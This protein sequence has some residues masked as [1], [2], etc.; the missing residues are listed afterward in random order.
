MSRRVEEE[1][2]RKNPKNEAIEKMEEIEEEEEED[3]NDDEKQ[4]AEND[5]DGGMH[6]LKPFRGK[7]LFCLLIYPGIVE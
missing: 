7:G 1:G 4:G 5:P 3:E 6:I 2:R